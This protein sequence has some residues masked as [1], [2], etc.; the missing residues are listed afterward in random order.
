MWRKGWGGGGGGGVSLCQCIIVGIVQAG[1]RS[2]TTVGNKKIERR[3]LIEAE[4]HSR[5]IDRNELPELPEWLASKH[6][7]ALPQLDVNDVVELELAERKVI[8]PC[9]AE[10]R[11]H[12]PTVCVV[13]AFRLPPT[14][15][16]H[17]RGSLHM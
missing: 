15:L 10:M 5:P 9:L 2:A 7:Q 4:V 17:C 1:S 14:H 12:L 3:R 6:T 13:C 11:S 16:K 8:S